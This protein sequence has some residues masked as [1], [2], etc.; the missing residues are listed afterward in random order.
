MSVISE[1]EFTAGFHSSITTAPAVFAKKNPNTVRV[2]WPWQLSLTSKEQL[3]YLLP[4]S[5]W[6]AAIII[7]VQ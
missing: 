2:K 7:V 3:Q 4:F 5:H 6:I 1:Y